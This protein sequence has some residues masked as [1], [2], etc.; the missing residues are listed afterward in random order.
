MKRTLILILASILLGA[1]S[2]AA[3]AVPDSVR[4][5]P[6]VDSTLAGKDVF[7]LIKS[8]RNGKAQ[9]VQS[10][11]LK[12][13]FDNYINANASKPL[14]GYRIRVYYDNDQ[15]SRSRSEAIA[16]QISAAYPGIGVY[17]TFESPNFKVTVGDFRTRDEALALFNELKTKYPAAFIIKDNI[18]YPPVYRNG[19]IQ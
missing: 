15:S 9:I 2:A 8:A 19:I 10:A 12:R 14:S 17:R 11:A 5:A 4:R 7:T 18:E 1:A 3:Q 13:A 16:R 6:A